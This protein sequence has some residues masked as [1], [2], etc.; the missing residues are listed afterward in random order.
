MINRLS[1]TANLTDSVNCIALPAS[2]A[3]LD[4]LV[5]NANSL[6][7]N[8]YAGSTADIINSLATTAAFALASSQSAQFYCTNTGQWH[9]VK[10]A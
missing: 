7:I 2:A 5:A 10:S 3:G 9:V 8:V 6:S 1:Q 4:L